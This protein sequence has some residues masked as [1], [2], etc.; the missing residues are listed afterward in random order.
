MKPDHKPVLPSLMQSTA[1]PRKLFLLLTSFIA[2]CA[3]STPQRTPVKMP[4]DNGDDLVYVV[5][6]RANIKPEMRSVFNKLAARVV[7]TLPDQ[8]G[9]ITY[10]LRRE[11]FGTQEWTMTVWNSAR[12]RDDF[13]QS[14][15]H[16]SAMKL[17]SRLVEDF[18]VRRFVVRRSQLPLRWQ[19]VLVGTFSNDGRAQLP[20]ADE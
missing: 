17:T 1:W 6:T 11:L 12:E 16:R 19:D 2:G 9:L 18:D 8:P 4:G 7:D 14:S 15:A 10:S 20:A 5:V 13:G 3:L